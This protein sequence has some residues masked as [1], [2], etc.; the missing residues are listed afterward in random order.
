MKKEELREFLAC[1][2]AIL[3]SMNAILH[4][5]HSQDV[6]QFSNYYVYMRK[7]NELLERIAKKLKIDTIADYCF[8]LKKVKSPYD[9]IAM[10]QKEYFSTVH[11]N[12]SILKSYLENKLD[13][14]KDE[15]TNLT[16]FLQSKLRSA[17]F[18]AP[19]KEKSIQD[20]IEQ[21]LIG[22]GLVKGIDYDRETGRVKVSIK[23]STPDFIF[24]KLD[25]AL[26]VKFSHSNNKSKSIVDE[27]NADIQAYSKK[28]S[29]LLFLIYDTG[30]I[31]NEDE[32]KNGIDNQKNI[33]V[34][35][36]KH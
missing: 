27:L 6:W 18:E 7:Y 20:A 11:A 22:R 30:F 29:N 19:T 21:L 15:I 16:N 9:T 5:Q 2:N 28:Y 17:I 8:D 33:I 14:K 4:T 25:L 12:L 35:I 31:R 3:D 23:E 13:L 10:Q 36:V 34:I 1:T 32:F 26:E 24:S